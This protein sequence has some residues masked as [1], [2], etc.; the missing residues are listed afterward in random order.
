MGTSTGIEVDGVGTSRWIDATAMEDGLETAATG[1][2]TEG[3]GATKMPGESD[4]E[5]AASEVP[6]AVVEASGSTT[7]VVVIATVSVTTS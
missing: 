2:L 5:G 3:V 6:L 1:W 7:M 4:E